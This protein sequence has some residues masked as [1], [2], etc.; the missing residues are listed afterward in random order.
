V[1]VMAR[2]RLELVSALPLDEPARQHDGE[3]V[4]RVGPR[5]D[6]HEAPSAEASVGASM[7]A[8]DEQSEQ[9]FPASDPPSWSRLS[10]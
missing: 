4:D 10:I 8:V 5:P 3:T 1:F 9:S 6:P 7:D 2:D